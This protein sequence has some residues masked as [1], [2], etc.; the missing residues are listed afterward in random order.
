MVSEAMANLILFQ[1]SVERPELYSLFGIKINI[2]ATAG[3][4]GPE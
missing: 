4:F 3:I 1:L 2:V